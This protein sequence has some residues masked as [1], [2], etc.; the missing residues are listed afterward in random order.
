[1]MK[2]LSV[3]LLAFLLLFC[4]SSLAH[5]EEAAPEQGFTFRDG[6]TW[7][8]TPAEVIAGMGDVP[9]TNEDASGLIGVSKFLWAE[10]VPVSTIEAGDINFFFYEDQ[11]FMIGYGFYNAETKSDDFATIKEALTIKY[12]EPTTSAAN[13]AASAKNFISMTGDQYAAQIKLYDYTC[14]TFADTRIY[15]ANIDDSSFVV[16]YE[17]LPLLETRAFDLEAASA[18]KEA[19]EKAAS[20]AA[21]TFGL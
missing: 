18:E 7:S 20:D 4:V 8:S 19:A 21:K 10:K 17:N 9:V 14:W 13:K 1:M 16:C 11:L 15:I 3:Y 12:G 2:K 5:A 6:I